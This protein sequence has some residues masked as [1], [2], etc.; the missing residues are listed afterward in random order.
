[1]PFMRGVLQVELKDIRQK[2]KGEWR[3]KVFS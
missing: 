2:L 1:M 3:Q